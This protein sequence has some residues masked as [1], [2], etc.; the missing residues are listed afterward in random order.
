MS[1]SN[2]KPPTVDPQD[3][4]KLEL[5]GN[6]ETVKIKIGTL[7]INGA[8][9]RLGPEAEILID[10]KPLPAGVFQVSFCWSATSVPIISFDCYAFND[11][12]NPY[13]APTRE[14]KEE[15][16]DDGDETS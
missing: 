9:Q 4:Q 15:D 12:G 8:A 13:I 2:Q 16:T 5:Y 1:S 10:G 7:E 14:P 11:K 6:P 3:I